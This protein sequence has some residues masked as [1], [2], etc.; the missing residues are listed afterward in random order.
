MHKLL[1]ISFFTALDMFLLA[2][3]ISTNFVTYLNLDTS[4]ISH[5]II[6]LYLFTNVLFFWDYYKFHSVTTNNIL[7]W[8]RNSLVELGLFGTVVG[9]F[10][11]FHK[12]FGTDANLADPETMRK[13]LAQLSNGFSIAIVSTITGVFTT[14][15][16]K[17]KLIFHAR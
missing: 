10:I 6:A 12:L 9:F 3:L 7:G 4:F 17:L 15:L 11:V 8:I 5:S 16:L 1:V 2:G 14:L 13:V